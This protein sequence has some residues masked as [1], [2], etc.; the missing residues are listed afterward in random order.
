MLDIT[1][2][3]VEDMSIEDW[4]VTEGH[5]DES[6]TDEEWEQIMNSEPEDVDG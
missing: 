1:I 2:S 5:T 6:L 3:E 4:L